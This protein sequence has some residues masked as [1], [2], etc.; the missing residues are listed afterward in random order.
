MSG[1]ENF[2]RLKKINIIVSSNIYNGDKLEQIKDVLV[3]FKKE[4]AI[5]LWE[6]TR[7]DIKK[8]YKDL[9]TEWLRKLRDDIVSGKQKTVSLDTSIID[10]VILE[11]EG[12]GRSE[13][14]KGKTKEKLINF[15]YHST[16]ILGI[17]K[18]INILY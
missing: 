17:D 9:D 10:E 8:I 4:Y 14:L 2:E 15:S 3:D 13:S 18:I 7:D 12:V 6:P 16:I 1:T 5:L 11:R